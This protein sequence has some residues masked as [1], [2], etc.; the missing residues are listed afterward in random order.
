MG[1]LGVSSE[2]FILEAMGGGTV[3]LG[4]GTVPLGG[5]T[6]PLGG[7]TVPLGSGTVTLGGGTVPLGDL[8]DLSVTNDNDPGCD[9]P[10]GGDIPGRSWSPR[11]TLRSHY[12]AIRGVTFPPA[13][14]AIVTASEDATLK[15][16]NLQ[17][18]VPNKKWGHWG[19]GQGTGMRGWGHAWRSRVGD[20]TGDTER[21]G[22]R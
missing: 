15:L 4:G 6:V 18:T 12:D 11:F 10:E 9:V 22:D 19:G 5:G 7:G 21:V 13:H 14:E 20:K 17:K 2:L 16:W 8:A 3:P 1:P